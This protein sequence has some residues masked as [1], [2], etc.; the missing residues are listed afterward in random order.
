MDR[1]KSQIGCIGGA[2]NALV[3]VTHDADVKVITS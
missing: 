2:Y 3:N 1:L